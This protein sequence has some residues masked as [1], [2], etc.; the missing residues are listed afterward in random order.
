MGIHG[1]DNYIAYMMDDIG[2][3]VENKCKLVN[4]FHNHKNDFR[5]W[6][7]KEKLNYNLEFKKLL[8]C[9]K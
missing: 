3:K 9:E 7:E 4:T 1:C 2:F 5:E 8:K 6:N